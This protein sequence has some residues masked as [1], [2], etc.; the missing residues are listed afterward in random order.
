MTHDIIDSSP[1]SIHSLPS[2]FDASA[3][4][5]E[6]THNASWSAPIGVL[7]SI[8]MSAVFG[9]FLIIALLFSIQDFKNTIQSDV[10]QPVV[11]ILVDIFGNTAAII[12][13]VLVIVCVWH[14]GLF[15]MTSNS[16]MMYG[17]SRDRGNSLY[18]FKASSVNF[19]QVFLGSLTRL[20]RASNPQSAP[21]GS[22]PHSP[23]SWHS[24]LLAQQ[25]LSRP[26]PP[27]P[28]SDCIFLTDYP[29]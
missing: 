10:G 25:S 19:S 21:S 6:E 18:P 14:C 26:Q 11:Q 2:S 23:S 24:H 13:M 8:G 4:L 17:F 22:P 7:M 28:R 20:M 9:F 5:S 1:S 15:S 12:L 3:H 29:S 27:S 16:R